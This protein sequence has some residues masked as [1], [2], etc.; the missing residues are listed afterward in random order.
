[1]AIMIYKLIWGNYIQMDS[2]RKCAKLDDMVTTLKMELDQDIEHKMNIVLVEGTDDKKLVK[3]VFSNQ[4]TCYESFSGKEGLSELI[5]NDRL[6]D[7]RII[8]IRDKD[9]DDTEQLP[10]RMWCYDTCCMETMLLKDKNVEEGLFDTFYKG[11][12]N[13]Q[14]FYKNLLR[15]LVPVSMLRRKN[16]EENLGINFNKMKLTEHFDCTTEKLDSVKV[17]ENIGHDVSV[18]DICCRE[19]AELSE[20]EL[21]DNTNGHDICKLLGVIFQSGK[22]D[23]GEER[24]RDSMICSYRS[25]DFKS[26]QLYSDIMC[27]QKKYNRKYVIE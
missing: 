26:T 5:Q 22:G 27:F 8:A 12:S 25:D 3:R 19:G 9:Y 4:I 2:I 10:E 13:R 23:M 20:E 1:M 15:Q 24:V 18:Y 11:E 16:E 6:K 14:T 17:F 21:Y 7:N